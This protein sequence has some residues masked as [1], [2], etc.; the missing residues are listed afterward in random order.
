[1]GDTAA[2]DGHSDEDT[3][4]MLAVFGQENKRSWKTEDDPVMGGQSESKVTVHQGSSDEASY[5]DYTGDC[6]IVPKLKAPGFTFALTDGQLTTSFPDVSKTDG[7]FLKVRNLEA[8]VTTFK[9]AF[10]DS[11]INPYACQMK[12]YK[13]DFDVAPAKDFADVFLPWSKFSNKWSPYTG[14]PTE[15]S[16]PK[17]DSLSSITQLQ[18]WVEGVAGHFHLQVQSIRAGKAPAAET[19]TTILV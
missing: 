13:A 16:P 9:F 2:A 8:N 15:P 19:T 4:V 5:L 1:M 14:E 3:S 10:C 12:T 6:R 11:R 7:V 18:I 17:A